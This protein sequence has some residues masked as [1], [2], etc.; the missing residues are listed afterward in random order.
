MKPK[1]S[2][3]TSIYKSSKFIY[4]FLIDVKRQTIFP[5]SE[6]LL[7]DAN[8]EGEDS[9]YDIIKDFLHL[10]PFKYKRIK[11]CNV[12]EAWNQGIE[13]ASG[14]LISNWNTDDR[15]KVNSLKT[16]VDFLEGNEEVDVCYGSLLL[17]YKENEVFEFCDTQ[18]T[19]PIFEG[20][21]EDQLKHN[22]PHCLP[23]WR[24]SIHDRFGD[25]DSSYFSAGDYEMWFRVLKGGGKLGKINEILGLYYNNQN[26]ISRKKEN[27]QKAIEECEKIRLQYTS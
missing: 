1:V 3:I 14:D 11:E 15:R 17:S 10:K 20:S 2:V 7:L 9:D 8:P 4:D 6:V 25:F 26:S 13:L 27:Y 24:K 19:W 23:V 5:E 16:Q 18:K 22:S 21:L 12:Y